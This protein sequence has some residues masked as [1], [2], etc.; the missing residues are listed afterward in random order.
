VV[1]LVNLRFDEEKSLFGKSYTAQ[2]AAQMLMRG[3]Q[4]RS[5]QQLQDELD[6]LKAH[7]NVAGGATG[8]SASIETVRDNL[9]ATLTLV[10]E[11][12]K[13]P[14]CSDTEFEQVRNAQV[15]QLQNFK[16]EPQAIASIALQQHMHP[17]PKG[18]VRAARS[19]DEQIKG[20]K[21]VTLA[22]VKR[23]YADYYGASNGE[24]TVSGDFDPA[25]IKKL[26]A[27][28]GHTRRLTL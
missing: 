11:I 9:P 4:K 28:G 25:Q 12:L 26:A 18:D 22:D 14:G 20:L 21:G 10:A 24:L 6:K 19:Y 5:R 1:A 16:N 13:E 7:I 17:Y 3:T 23:F 15:A 2:L 8:A 27:A